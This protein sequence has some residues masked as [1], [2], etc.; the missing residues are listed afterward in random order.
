MAYRNVS[1]EMI[2][3]SSHYTKEETYWFERLAGEPEKTSFPYDYDPEVI[4]AGEP[5]REP[6]RET[7]DFRLTGDIFAKLLWLANDSDYRLHMVLTAAL[8]ALLIKY[9]FKFS[10]LFLFYN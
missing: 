2:V 5:D 4:K 10:I 7:V 6:C 9:S 3:A 1:D 8:L